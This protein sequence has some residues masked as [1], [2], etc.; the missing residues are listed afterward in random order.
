MSAKFEYSI[1]I[2]SRRFLVDILPTIES[3]SKQTL[4]PKKVFIILDKSI[5]KDF[6]YKY[7]FELSQN[8]WELFSNIEIVSCV[9]YDFTPNN[10]VSY[11]RNFGFSLVNTDLV[12]SLDDDNVFEPEFC[13]RLVSIVNLLEQKTLLVPTE[14]HKN[15]VRSRGYSSFIYRL[16][17]Q[18][19]LFFPKN[20]ICLPDDKICPIQFSSSN[21]IFG[22]TKIFQ[23][24][25]FDERFK[26]IYEDFDFT[27]RVTKSGFDMFVVRWLNINHNMRPKNILEDKYIANPDDVFQKSQN[28]ILFV[29]NTWSL[30]QK[31]QYFMFGLHIHSAFIVY[32]IIRFAPLKQKISLLRSFAFWT[33]SWILKK[34]FKN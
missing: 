25:K 1:V 11:V 8:F 23:Q 21:C 17:K 27:R 2:P 16:G 32:N 4:K 24:I 6:L 10:W 31:I 19:S 20:C 9:D 15:K 18:K 12:L 7:K 22:S 34:R 13:A 30:F 28:R 26:F 29:K 33:R 14:I 5:D 3:I